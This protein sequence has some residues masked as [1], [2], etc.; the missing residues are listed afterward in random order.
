MARIIYVGGRPHRVDDNATESDVRRIANVA[1]DHFLTMQNSD[2]QGYKIFD[3]RTKLPK[4]RDDLHM[5]SLPKYTQ[6]F[7]YKKKR[8]LQEVSQISMRHPVQIDD[9]NLNYITVMKFNLNKHFSQR[10]TSLLIEIPSGYPQVP[11]IHFYMQKT[12]TYKGRCPT[13]YF[14]EDSSLFN[15]KLSHLGWGKYCLHIKGSWRPSSNIL[16]GDSLLTFL[17][18]IKT[19]LDNLERSR[20]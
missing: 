14:K 13:H 1:D 6:G 8:I 7:D 11:P 2:P 19:V 10:T 5:T 15:N 16:D 3:E 18:L 12:L 17:E 4:G 20:V 9:N